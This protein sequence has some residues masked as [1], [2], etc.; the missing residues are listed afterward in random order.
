MAE[1]NGAAFV[2]GV[3]FTTTIAT[4]L[5]PEAKVLASK[6][7]QNVVSGI[8]PGS[9]VEPYQSKLVPDLIE[10]RV[11]ASF[12]IES[13]TVLPKPRR[14]GRDTGGPLRSV[15]LMVKT[16]PSSRQRTV[17]RPASV[18]SAPYLPALVASSCSVRPMAWAAAAFRCSFGPSTAIRDPIRSAKCA[19]WART[20]YLGNGVLFCYGGCHR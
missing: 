13:T 12:A 20:R 5:R 4:D 10:W 19:S 18:E 6:V 9:S 3:G 14:S 1:S 15:Q 11:A 7:A 16:S 2:A 8:I 17:T